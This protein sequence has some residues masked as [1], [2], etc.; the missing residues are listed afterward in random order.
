[1][2]E[3]HYLFPSAIASAAAWMLRGAAR[4]ESGRDYLRELAP[5]GWK[6]RLRHS[7]LLASA[8]DLLRWSR[9]N[10]ID[11]IHAHSCAHSAHVLAIARRMGGPSYSLTLHG[12][13]GVYGTGHRSKMSGAAFI[14]AVGNHL[15]SQIL[16]HTD[17][18]EHRII[19]TCMGVEV[20]KLAGLG[21]NRA[22][23]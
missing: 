5:E 7:A 2:A 14:C 16:E 20:A 9:R 1:V 18:P 3:T 13:L 6:S 4:L 21:S 17:V 15:R 23:V 19:T 11:H 22:F 10:R 8:V 12:D